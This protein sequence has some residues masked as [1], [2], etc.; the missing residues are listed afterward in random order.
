MT[1]EIEEKYF[2]AENFVREGKEL[3]AVQI[4]KQL[5]DEKKE[6]RST[7]IRLAH[8]YE[9]MKLY[10]KVSELLENFLAAEKDD[11]VAF[12]YGQF[13]MR[14]K[15]FSKAVSVFR[16]LDKTERPD[17]YYFCAVANYEAGRKN[18]ALESFEKYL[19]SGNKRYRDKAL[20]ACS[21]T[22][23]ELKDFD[24]ALDCLDEFD[25][26]STAANG[27]TQTLYAKIYHA[28]GLNYY[29]QDAIE[30]TLKQGGF[31][32]EVYL[33]AGKI[34]YSL[35]EFSEAEKFF[36]AL[37]DKG[38]ANPEVYSLLG[39]CSLANGKFKDARK[40]LEQAMQKNP[41]DKNVILLKNK[42]LDLMEIKSGEN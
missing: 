26:I 29:A 8:L 38:F 32:E 10:D 1:S 40:Y 36:G 7:L 23:Y 34:Y 3:F 28:K 39:F 30:K 24:R 35:G 2:Q 37:L 4:Y 5:L 22:S 27:K 41:F 20:F 31:S 25:K 14:I 18:D 6:P 42:L 17:V 19:Q 21:K 11:E 13:L 16:E 12:L 33:L 15:N 9:K